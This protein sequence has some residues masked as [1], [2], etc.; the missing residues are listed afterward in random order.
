[1]SDT[2]TP[3]TEALSPSDEARLHLAAHA[4][5]LSDQARALVPVQPDPAPGTLLRA[6]LE[7]RQ[8]VDAVLAAAAV[9]E[10]ERGVTWQQ[11]GKATNTARQSVHQKWHPAIEAWAESG[12]RAQHDTTGRALAAEL[13]DWVARTEPERA[14]AVSAGLDAVRFPG[15]EALETHQRLRAESLH[16]RLRQALAA[17]AEAWEAVNALKLPDDDCGVDHPVNHQLVAAFTELAEVYEELA[18]AEPAL[19]DDHHASAAWWR[20]PAQRCR[21]EGINPQP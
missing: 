13:D 6:A 18:G 5:C 19:A 11:L 4:A 21:E 7:L 2:T 3:S 1:M 8:Q 9:A 17:K 15:S 10:R 20:E 14:D 16:E 12:R